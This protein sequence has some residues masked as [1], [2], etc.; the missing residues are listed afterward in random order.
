MERM[1]DVREETQR[2]G[3]HSAPRFDK[4]WEAE[5]EDSIFLI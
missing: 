4:E 3:I 1:G 5:K 2:E